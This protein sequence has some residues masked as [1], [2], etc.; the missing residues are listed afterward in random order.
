MEIY[1]KLVDIVGKDNA[2]VVVFFAAL[3]ILV[4]IFKSMFQSKKS[5]K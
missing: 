1:Q 4:P 2:P 3:A 5:N